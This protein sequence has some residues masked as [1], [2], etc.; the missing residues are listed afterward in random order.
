MGVFAG[1]WGSKFLCFDVDDGSKESVAT[2]IHELVKLGLNRNQIHVSFSGRKGYHVEIFFEGIV[3]TDRLH[4]LYQH[5]IQN[6]D[7]DP[8]KVE[9]RPTHTS[10]IKL[11]LSVHAK[12]G[13]VCWFVDRNTFE[14]VENTDYLLQIQPIPASSIELVLARC[15]VA[16]LTSPSIGAASE[17]GKASPDTRNL[18]TVVQQP[19]TRHNIMRNMVVYMRTHG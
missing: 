17:A 16:E 19:G 6:G 9:F 13:N 4:L 11:P 12:T 3:S 14:P 18:G 1:K 15:H 2:I 10:A 5:V 8:H 7:L